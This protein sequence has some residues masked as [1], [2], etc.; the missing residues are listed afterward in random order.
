MN[1]LQKKFAVLDGQTVHSYTLKN[2]AMEVT[3]INY[4]CIITKIL[5]PDQNGVLENIVLGFDS[6]EEYQ[7]FSPYFG[8]VVGRT[9]GRIKNGEFELDG[10]TYILPQNENNNHLHGGIEGFDRKLWDAEV[11]EAE[12]EVGVE[13]SYTSADGEEG[14]P[15]NL[16]V[17]VTYTLNNQNEFV[18]SYHGV[19]DQKTLVNLTNHTYFNLSGN[20]KRDVLEHELTINSNQFAELNM[21]LIPTGEFIDVNETAFDLREGKKIREGVESGHPQNLLAGK[22]YDHPFLLNENN[23]KEIVL[24]DEE[25]GRK[26]IVKTDEPSVVLYTGN[27]LEGQFDIR[28]TKSRNYSGLCLETQG[29]PDSIHHSHFPSCVL[30]KDE[31]YFTKTTYMFSTAK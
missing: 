16:K 22:G 2:D 11:I 31:E 24:F 21:E 19:S 15:G 8:A 6:L 13:F 10:Q 9:A 14:Y 23:H 5:T 4:G 12:N 17:T 30:E 1:V 18:I 7:K 29:L 20:L 25:S 26:M 3:C 27:K 28:G